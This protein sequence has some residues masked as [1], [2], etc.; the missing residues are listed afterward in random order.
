MFFF[1]LVTSSKTFFNEIIFFLFHFF[2][3]LENLF[4]ILPN[5]G[6]HAIK[7]TFYVMFGF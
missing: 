3:K 6:A 7:P 5:L 4:M 1:F 2:M